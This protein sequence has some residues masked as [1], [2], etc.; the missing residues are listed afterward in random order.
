MTKLYRTCPKKS[1]VVCFDEFGPLELKPQHGY[2]WARTGHPHRQPAT[3]TR[4]NGVSHF[5]GFLDVHAN[6]LWGYFRRRK[7]SRETLVMLQLLRKRY[8]VNT[9]IYLILDN[10]SPHRTKTVLRWSKNNNI[11]LIWT[12]TN[13]SW[14]NHI[15]CRFTD[16]KNSVFTNVYYKSHQEVYRAVNKYLRYRNKY[17]NTSE[18]QH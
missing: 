16:I 1:V 5:F 13:A 11:I 12:P 4:P 18:K 7:R 3:Y 10:F 8:P 15:E 17:K 14:L 2:T 6:H 9:R